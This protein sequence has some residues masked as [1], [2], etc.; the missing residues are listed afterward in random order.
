MA[1]TVERTKASPEMNFFGFATSQQ[2]ELLP[3]LCCASAGLLLLVVFC[4]PTGPMTSAAR[5]QAMNQ[6]GPIRL[7]GIF[8]APVRGA[9]DPTVTL[10][11]F[12]PAKKTPRYSFLIFFPD[13]RV[14]K[15][16]ITRGLD[17]YL[18]ESQMRHDIASG[19]NTAAQ[20]G[21]YQ[22]SGSG[23]RI[24]FADARLGGQQLVY[25]L[26]GEAWSI[27]VYPDKLEIRGDDYVRLYGG[28][29]MSLQGSY[30]PFGDTKSPGITFT[31]DGEFADEGILNSGTSTGV[32]VVGGG[33][34]MGYV[35]TSPGPGRGTYNIVKYGLHLHYANG[36]APDTLFFL[37]PGETKEN[38]QILY[39]NNVKYERVP[40]SGGVTTP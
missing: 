13:G 16:L 22:I 30:K 31:P 5:A 35:F 15:G 37:E 25:G 10:D 40:P 24:V 4:V 17:E 23:G 9:A 7:F 39:I 20:W 29:G 14:K 11:V 36:K 32:G 26:R 3:R 21:V 8:R 2:V 38:P 28:N 34:A 1:K 27:V 33:L 19:G 12:D 6:G 18:D